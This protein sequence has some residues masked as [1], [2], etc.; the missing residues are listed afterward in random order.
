[1]T[2]WLVAGARDI[3]DWVLAGPLRSGVLVVA[4]AGLPDAPQVLLDANC[5]PG[6]LPRAQGGLW[7][8]PGERSLPAGL[9]V[10]ASRAAG[11]TIRLRL[12]DQVL[13]HDLTGPVPAGSGPFVLR[14]G[15][16]AGGRTGR[17]WLA[18]DDAAG[19]PVVAGAAGAGAR[20][21][22]AALALAVCGAAGLN[23][24]HAV[25]GAIALRRA[26]PGKGPAPEHLA[27]GAA[28]SAQALVPLPGGALR[29]LGAVTPG[30]TVLDAAGLPRRLAMVHL[31]RVPPG[32][33]F[34]PLRLRAGRLPLAQDLLAGPQLALAFAGDDVGRLFGD[35]LAQV[36]VRAAHL[37]DPVQRRA[38]PVGPDF[39]MAVPVPEQPAILRIGQ[40]AVACP[41]QDGNAPPDP[42]LSAAETA[43]LLAEGGDM[44][45]HAGAS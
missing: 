15:W 23:Q 22:P 44:R 21:W 6:P 2:R 35:R 25:V 30:Q 10:L 42:V 27:R 34:S 9:S 37:P 29:P 39:L 1:M 41:D 5:G 13:R 17:W 12:G 8:M 3:P 40:L 33:A 32:F 20:P 31:F 16:S 28:I 7:P 36:L 14:M 24:R 18:L 45:L 19:K 11:V 43:A 38:L 26:I 4:L